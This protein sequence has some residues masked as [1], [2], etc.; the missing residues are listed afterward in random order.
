MFQTDFLFKTPSMAAAVIAGYSINGR[1]Y[2]RDNN[3]LSLKEI[4]SKR[5]YNTQ[6][7]IFRKD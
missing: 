5:V 3:G 6:I 2:W 1:E 7:S 4:E